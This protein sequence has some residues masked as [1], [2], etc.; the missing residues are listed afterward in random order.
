MKFTLTNSITATYLLFF[1]MN[2]ATAQGFITIS[3]QKFIKNNQPY[4]FIGTNFWYGM[5]LAAEKSGNRERLIRELD[6]LK[7][8]GIN[9]L[10][11]MAGSEGP[12]DAPWRIKPAL[13][14]EL[15]IYNQD[16]LQGLDFLFDEMR[17]REMYAVVCLNNFW[18]WSGGMAQYVNWYEISDIP[19]PPP[20]EN[21]SWSKYQFYTA[22][23]YKDKNAQEAFNKHIKKIV[24]RT[25]SYSG[26]QYK[27]DP[28]IMAWQL[29]N[30]PRGILSKKAFNKWIDKT[31]RLIKSLDNNHLL[32][33]GSEGKT[34]TSFTGN[35]VKKNHRSQYIDYMTIHIWV[36]NWEWYH[37]NN[38]EESLIYAKEKAE[39]YIKKHIEFAQKLKMPLV[40]EEFGISRDLDN[41]SPK[42]PVSVRDNY[43]EFIFDKVIDYATKDTP[44]AGCNFWAWGGEGRPAEPKTIWKEGD[45]FIGD[46]PHEYQGWYSVYDT[47]KST[48]NVISSAIEKVNNINK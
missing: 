22:R 19:Y 6:R 42:S 38:A 9:N 20:A 25:N 8:L 11:I 27:H 31:A 28:A 33:V 24:G 3:D 18:P 15:G 17:K 34:H 32:T 40:L 44:M 36:Q 10:R 41:H 14:P 21:G 5:N 16:L 47:D 48:L 35:Q 23:F 37:P 39:N 26:I 4:Y 13:Q 12:D 7:A 2:I 1:A 46:P 30:E 43:Y 45:D 29:A